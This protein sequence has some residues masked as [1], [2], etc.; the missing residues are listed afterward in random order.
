[1]HKTRPCWCIKLGRIG[2]QI[3]AALGY[4]MRPCWCTNHSC[5]GVQNAAVFCTPTRLS[6]MHQHGRILCTECCRVGAHTMAAFC[7]PMRL[8]LYTNTAMFCTPT[9]LEFMHQHS[10]VL[11]THT[12]VF[13]APTQLCF[14]HRMQPCWCTNHDHTLFPNAAVFCRSQIQGVEVPGQYYLLT[15]L[16]HEEINY[17]SFISLQP[18]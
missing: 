2:V 7:S 3:T 12:A 14:V 6:F 15:S 17:S 13:Y 1:M 11:C 4:K 8:F 16:L 10:C 9:Q 18:H 5:I